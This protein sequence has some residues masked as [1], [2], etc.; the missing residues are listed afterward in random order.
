MKILVVDAFD[1]FVHILKQYLM[2]LDVQP[3]VVRSDEFVPE[4]VA[5]SGAAALLLGPGPGHP[6]DSGHVE[7]VHRFAG[8]VPIMGVCLGQQAVGVA[9]GARV[10][11]AADLV[12][13][14]ASVI[15]HDGAGLFTGLPRHFR[16]MRYHSL[17]VDEA[18]VPDSL[19]VTARSVDGNYVMGLRHTALPIETTQFHP[20]SVGS[21]HGHSMIANFLDRCRDRTAVAS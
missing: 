12:H 13:G 8:Q 18:S 1:S 17:V 7:I 3:V 9:F 4:L 2:D 15:D 20:E 5:R 6:A 16:A 10:E 14:K 19:R 11:R 21:E